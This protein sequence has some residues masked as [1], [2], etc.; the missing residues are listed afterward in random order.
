MLLPLSEEAGC[1]SFFP[2]LLLYFR[3]LFHININNSCAR[4]RGLEGRVNERRKKEC[5][6][7]LELDGLNFNLFAA[8]DH[9]AAVPH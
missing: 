7:F 2:L 5:R 1:L 4:K 3:L 9:S 8:A 6:Q